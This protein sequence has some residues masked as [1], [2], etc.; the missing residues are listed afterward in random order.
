MPPEVVMLRKMQFS[1]SGNQSDMYPL[2]R[3]KSTKPDIPAGCNPA[4]VIASGVRI[5]YPS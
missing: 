4:A 2:G 5:H 3:Q 1:A